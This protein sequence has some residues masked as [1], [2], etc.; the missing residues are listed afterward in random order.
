MLETDDVIKYMQNQSIIKQARP[1]KAYIGPLKLSQ[2]PTQ[3]I[4]NQS[5]LDTILGSNY[6]FTALH[7]NLNID[8]KHCLT[9]HSRLS[10]NPQILHHIHQENHY[11]VQYVKTTPL[12]EGTAL[13]LSAEGSTPPHLLQCTDQHTCLEYP[14]SEV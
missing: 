11:V 8:S 4:L 9:S 2:C 14:S 6:S 1:H 12:P 13:Q 3:D 7:Q 10:L 5:V